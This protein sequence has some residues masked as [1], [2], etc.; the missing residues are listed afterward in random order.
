MKLKSLCQLIKKR[1][2]LVLL[3]FLLSIVLI[4]TAITF[5]ITSP[6]FASKVKSYASF[7]LTKTLHKQVK[8]KTLKISIFAP[9]L[10]I[11]GVNIKNVAYIKE[12]N[13]FFGPLN[14]FQRKITIDKIDI[15]RPK[16]NILIKNNKI[17]NYKKINRTIKSLTKQ[18][19]FSLISFSFQ[20]IAFH[21]GNFKLNDMDRHI[22]LNLKN[23]DLN[24]FK[25]PVLNQLFYNNNGIY[26]SYDL[27]HIFLSMSNISQVYNSSALRI[28]YF[29]GFIKFSRVSFGS[30]YFSSAS[31]GILYLN[32]EPGIK[33]NVLNL[34]KETAANE[35]GFNFNK[36]IDIFFNK[37]S[38]IVSKINDTT[39]INFN[40]LSYISKNFKLIPLRMK[41]K[42]NARL[43]VVGD[44]SKKIRSSAQVHLK[45]FVFRGGDVKDGFVKCNGAFGK[46]K[47]QVLKFT[48][49][50]L[51]MF[52]GVVESSGNINFNEN[53]GKF[54]S[55]LKDMDIGRLIEF[56]DSVKIPQ[57]TALANGNVKTYLHLGKNFY[58][59]NI[60][61]IKV[62][63]PEQL[64]KF[65]NKKGNRV[66]YS[67]NYG[68]PVLV[69]GSVI[70]NDKLVLLKDLH[71]SSSQ[72]NGVVNG[73]ISYNKKHLNI[74][75]YGG[76]KK[77]PE[78]D[79]IEA[80]KS[81][82][83]QPAGSGVIKGVIV[84]KFNN[85][86][87]DF[88]N[89]FKSLYI[90]RYMDSYKGVVNVNIEPSGE[91][92][93][94]Q[95]NL[96][97]KSQK[98]NKL[99]KGT[100]NF[101]GRIYENKTL[102]TEYIDGK[103]ETKNIRIIS[104][105]PALPLF[106]HLNSKGKINGELGN[107]VVDIRAYTEKVDV[108]GQNISNINSYAILTKKDL[109]IK[110]LNGVYN[111]ANFNIYGLL[112]FKP[113]V[114]NNF[115]YDLQLISNGINLANLNLEQVKKYNV[116][117]I[118]NLNLHIGGLFA[119]P[120]I[121]GNATIKDI[122]I[123]DY[124]LENI[125]VGISSS[126]SRMVLNLSALK[127]SLKTKAN[128][129]L[130]KGYPY[131]FVTEINLLNINYR[132]TQFRLS[133]GIYGSGKLSNIK[134]SYLFAKLTYVY[135]KH[136]P[137]FLKNIKN[138]RISYI[139]RALDLSGFELKGK[140]NYLQIRGN[141]TLKKYNLVINDRTDLWV[142]E[143]LSS[144]IINS[145]GFMTS[146]AVV[147]GQSS[148]PQVYGFAE[149][150][151]GL[152]ETQVNPN[153]TISRVF[154]RLTFNN[155]SIVLDKG[156]FRLLNGIFSARGMVRLSDFKPVSYNLKT[157]FNSAIYR[158][159]NYFY[160]D[161]NGSVRYSGNA[162]TGTIYGDINIKKALYDKKINFSSFL[163]SYRKYNIIRPMIKKGVFNPKLNLL[164][165]ANKSIFI[166]NNIMDSD[167]SSRL[168]LIGTLYD[169]IL[170]GTANTETGNIYFR[171]TEFRLSYANID[172]NNPY[173][174]S[175][176][177]AVS[178]NTHINQYIVRINASGSLLNF[179]V[180][181]S[182]TPPL[183]ELDIVSMLAL[184]APTSSVYAGSAGGIAASEAASAIGG[185]LEQSVT[186]AISSYFGFKNLSV[187]PSYS[188]VT[189]SAAPQVTVTKTITKK[190]SIS[191]SNIISSQS[192]QSVTLTYKLAPHIS[193]IGIWENNELASNNSNIYSEV[194]G[195][196]VFHFRF[197]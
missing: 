27:P 126:K 172:F 154:A 54:K 169:P 67:I 180:N 72:L 197:Y 127:N 111:G 58:I 87:F 74:G 124:F 95:V 84:G 174:I 82:Y 43:H 14:F 104:K 99:N 85:I 76:Y 96:K 184:G 123:N 52:N 121:S 24:I 168:H 175:P 9:Q 80:V 55:I 130:K 105:K 139:N 103:F 193:A 178:A 164:I 119:L 173:K 167:F 46:V 117:G 70:V 137:F 122:Y 88:R 153:Y 21:K 155:N 181:L 31:N 8:I 28:H 26:F 66:I 166:K 190:M 73:T 79:F 45:N 144:K 142:V 86:S 107:P 77:L 50:N 35:V 141:V 171:G 19:A 38:Q 177:F 145:S 191:Y 61:K 12:I 136:G 16:F 156:R 42:L 159:S 71:A 162:K 100:I 33:K 187:A 195:S 98:F 185:G 118:A 44:F 51:K 90:N 101:N 192:S 37:I 196:I 48:E 7:Y 189:H 32:K 75:F 56:Y 40:H 57:F 147:F 91:V 131:S 3:I 133:G 81:R 182:S 62:K 18:S 29:N 115:N 49:I 188:A 68:K 69:T 63:K 108:Y 110:R 163:L 10:V 83:F 65:R 13:L 161:M 114:N 93:F 109:N 94:K 146:S 39:I 194:G 170:I 23:F 129:L 78:V 6:Y 150:K 4:S 25:R 138:I 53:E 120:D 15:I 22:L 160:A 112:R 116:R 157:D 132:K 113:S 148:H 89:R 158:K 20:D 64:L 47:N 151:K 186:G 140:N 125:D 41:G 34:H 11:K 149:I 36:K 165:K 30:N 152:L 143:L 59:A 92:L 1:F 2:N 176:T 102:K 134:N 17:A 183:S 5:F 135:L 128:I 60:E 97:E 106:L 179:N